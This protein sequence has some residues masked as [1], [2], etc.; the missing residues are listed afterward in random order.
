MTF[1]RSC[2]PLVTG[3]LLASACPGGTKSRV[4]TDYFERAEQCAAKSEPA[5][6]ALIRSVAKLARE[7]F[8]NNRNEPR[9]EE[10]CKQMLETLL[11]DPNCR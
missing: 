8:E 9:V 7:G 6:A 4:C 1:P 11:E 10:S 3:L 2:L 5:Q